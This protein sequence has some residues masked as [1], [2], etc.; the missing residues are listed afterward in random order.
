MLENDRPIFHKSELDTNHQENEI[1]IEIDKASFTW[2]VE[3][4]KKEN[5]VQ[6]LPILKDISIKIKK[7]ELLSNITSLV[8]SDDPWYIKVKKYLVI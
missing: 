4:D 7:G 2:I 1:A 8:S 5:Q 3:E 6:S